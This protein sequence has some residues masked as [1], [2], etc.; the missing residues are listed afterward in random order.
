MEKVSR[1]SKQRKPTFE[2]RADTSACRN[3][4]EKLC[5]VRCIQTK[6][7]NY[8]GSTCICRVPKTQLKKG[9]VVECVHC[10]EFLESIEGR[11]LANHFVALRRLQGMQHGLIAPYLI[12]LCFRTLVVPLYSHKYSEPHP[13]CSETE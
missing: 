7:M 13:H 12:V 5:C 11:R 8:T 2:L 1:L 3:G 4:Y 10:G 6:D 9:T